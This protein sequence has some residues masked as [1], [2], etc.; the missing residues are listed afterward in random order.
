MFFSYILPLGLF[1][2]MIIGIDA[3]RYCFDAQT[4]VERY[5][6]RVIRGLVANFHRELPDVHVHLYVAEMF[7]A[8]KLKSIVSSLDRI[9]I[10]RCRKLW[11]QVG[12]AQHLLHDSP[13]LL[14]VPSHVLPWSYR[15]KSVVVVHGLEALHFPK[16]YS[17]FVRWYQRFTTR[18]AVKNAVRLIAV[19][20]T[21]K[22]DLS[23]FFHCPEN[24]V[25]V[26]YEGVSPVVSSQLPREKI[27][28]SI[29]RIEER[30][31]Q[32]RLIQAFEKF[33]QS[34]P[35]YTLKLIGPDGF[36]AS[37]I[38][39][40]VKKLPSTV[41]EKISFP[42]YLPHNEAL[43]V[44]Q[45]ASLFA[46]PSLAEGFG[47]PILE[48]MSVGTPV[49]TSLG[50]ACAEIAGDAAKLVDPLDV[51]SIAAGLLQIVSDSQLARSLVT[52][53]HERVT[54]FSWEKCIEELF[55]VLR[56]TLHL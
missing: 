36:G 50:S 25:S 10:I 21:V 13:D 22:N 54:H 23:H 7:Q 48:A 29:G 28:V 40:Y 44:L 41:R 55:Q 33:F 14:F 9:D 11:T 34:H 46:Y 19:S 37:A 15:G 20:N 24:K 53:G 51:E 49:L 30:K 1:V 18:Y 42:G 43:K 3:S 6:D 32:F 56:S 47:L 31:N 38:H 27:I 5:T 45:T 16:A 17:R 52:E 4:G 12:L 2:A 26:V 39:Q 35:D 8:E